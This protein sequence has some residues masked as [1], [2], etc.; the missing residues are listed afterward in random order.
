MRPG[1]GLTVA[2]DTLEHFKMDCSMED[3]ML[4][5]GSIWYI[6]M[7]CGRI[8]NYKTVFRPNE[9][10]MASDIHDVFRDNLY[11]DLKPKAC[12]FSENTEFLRGAKEKIRERFMHYAMNDDREVTDDITD[13]E[14]YA[15]AWF[16]TAFA[17]IH[18]GYCKA[19][20][21]WA[22]KG[23]LAT[24]YDAHEACDLFFELSEYVDKYFGESKEWAEGETMTVH[25]NIKRRSF[26]I[27]TSRGRSF[28]A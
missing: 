28:D 26:N 19:R 1:Y 21:R 3:E 5:F 18:H 9:D 25:V 11:A 10:I 17:W 13:F 23:S 4:A 14:A 2:H 12:G 15:A 7:E 6:R 22:G 16:E 20:K 24:G 27:V 8:Q